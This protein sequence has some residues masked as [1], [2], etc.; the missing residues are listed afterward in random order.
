MTGGNGSVEDDRDVSLL[1]VDQ[2]FRWVRWSPVLS[3][4]EED[5]LVLVVERGKQERMKASPDQ[6]V[7]ALA[8][9]ARDR[10]V[11]SF[12][13]LVI[14]IATQMAHRFSHLEVMDV[15]QE[16]NLGLLRAIDENEVSRGY[17]LRSLAGAC[18][19]YAILDAWREQEGLVSCSRKAMA[20]WGRVARVST[21]YE[22]EQGREPTVSEVAQETGMS[23]AEV[24]EVQVWRRWRRAESL[25]ALQAE[26]ERADGE[27]PCSPVFVQAHESRVSP[28]VVQQAMAEVLTQRQQQ[29]IGLRY[30]LLDGD[31]QGMTHPEVAAR[32]GVTVS[33]SA[34]IEMNAERR[35]QQR[36]GGLV[37]L[38]VI[39]C[40]VCGQPV[41]Q[42]FLGRPRRYCHTNQCRWAAKK[43]L[44][45]EV[46]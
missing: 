7:Q 16:G 46:A 30:G 17:P 5:A 43:I 3:R 18:I 24:Y 33:D 41:P 35:L 22:Q 44:A 38:P 45:R 11:Q 37:G 31:G 26:Q 27:L 13:G 6:Q 12:Q 14:H 15:I 42:R 34:H 10:L 40:V 2:Y 28:A 19:R 21:R 8:A 36:L 32:L 9:S 23:A 20:D 39:C 29:V 1:A 4:E 25:H